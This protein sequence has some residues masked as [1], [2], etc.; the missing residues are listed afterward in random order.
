[1][2]KVTIFNYLYGIANRI[3]N[4]FDEIDKVA[5]NK[6]NYE[7]INRTIERRRAESKKFL[8]STIGELQ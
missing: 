4:S 2:T 1:M 8:L 5:E 3:I 7:E 6:I